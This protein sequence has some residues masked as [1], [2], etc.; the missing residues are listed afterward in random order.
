MTISSTRVVNPSRSPSQATTH[1]LLRRLQSIISVQFD[2]LVP[3]DFSSCPEHLACTKPI[4]RQRRFETSKI[5]VM[6]LQENGDKGI[7]ERKG[8]NNVPVKELNK[9]RLIFSRSRRDSPYMQVMM[10]RTMTH[11]IEYCSV[12]TALGMPAF[13]TTT[14]PQAS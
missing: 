11:L 6:E 5:N 10:V 4:S 7:Y 8:K 14:S 12:A 3:S 13:T 1:V 9:H 2:P